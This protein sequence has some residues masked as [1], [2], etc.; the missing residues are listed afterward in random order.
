[1]PS[2]AC[3]LG[4]RSSSPFCPTSWGAGEIPQLTLDYCANKEPEPSSPDY[5][6]ETN[7]PRYQ[8]SP[9]PFNNLQSRSSSI[10][11]VLSFQTS[12]SP[13]PGTSPAQGT[14]PCHGAKKSSPS[15]H[16]TPPSSLLVE[17]VS[18]LYEP[19]CK[20]CT[21]STAD[22]QHSDCSRMQ[23]FTRG[24]QAEERVEEE[25]GIVQLGVDQSRALNLVSTPT[26]PHINNTKPH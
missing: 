6:L 26:T 19:H 2:L 4:S 7:A 16:S 13:Y 22:P 5:N 10:S 20:F 15:P 12:H 24:I 8:G 3:T 21:K 18:Q 23:I 17:H 25:W 11:P 9:I 1:M 14:S